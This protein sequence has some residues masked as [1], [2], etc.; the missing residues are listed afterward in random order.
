MKTNLTITGDVTN[1]A[2]NCDITLNAT[3]TDAVNNTNPCAVVITRTWSLTD[4]CCNTTTHHQIITV[5]DV[6]PPTFTAP[7]DITIS[8][9]QDETNLT[10]TGDVT[11]EADNCDITLNA[12]YTD[13]VN[14]TNPCAVVIT[15]TWSLT[16]DCCNT[17][18][19]HQ[20]ITVVDLTPLL[21]PLRLTFTISCEQDETNLTI[22]GDVTNEADNCDITLNATYTDAVN[23]TNPC[24][25]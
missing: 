13:A 7:A 6:T 25:S 2:D 18:T 11:N 15:R 19:H 23:N 16:D 10:I 17:T 20:I 14:N 1:E 5:V 8:C 12:T 22:T 24:A 4:D 9:E 21:S 3:Y